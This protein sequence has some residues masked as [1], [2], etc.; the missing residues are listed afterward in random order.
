M[1]GTRKKAAATGTRGTATKGRATTKRGVAAKRGIALTR[2]AKTKHGVS[3]KRAVTSP[4]KSKP[5]KAPAPALTPAALRT[6]LAQRETELALINSIQQGLAAKLDFQAVVDLIGDQ[7][8]VLFATPDL[9]ISWFD[10][11]ANL[12]RTLYAYEHDRRLELPPSAPRPG[13][14][15]ESMRKSRVPHVLNRSL[16][17]KRYNLTPVPGTDNSKSML[18]VPIVVGDRF[19]GDISIENFERE[20]AFAPSDIRLVSTVAGSLGAAL[21][22]AR[23]FDETQRLLKETEQ[24]A[25]ELAVINSIQQGMA[26]KLDF[27][28]I[29]DLVGDK[30]R[31]VFGTGDIGIRWYDE[32]TNL[33]HYLYD[34]EH[35][36]RLTIPPTRPDA[37]RSVRDDDADATT[38]RSEHAR[39]SMRDARRGAVP[40]TDT[41]KSLVARADRRQRSRARQHHDRE[42][43]ARVRVRRS[44]RAAADDGRRE[45][46][47]RAGERA[48]LRRDAAAAQGNRAA[49]RRA[50]GHQQHPAGDRRRSSTSRR[51]SISSATSCARYSAPATSASAGTTSEPT[52]CI[53]CTTSSTACA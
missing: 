34:Y 13:G 28:A 9:S 40:G 33:S 43:R 30:L 23:L 50:R 2:G 46:G 24:R 39:P 10:E 27:Q 26:A 51:S 53:T 6:R 45:H 1:A 12:V 48:P 5:S 11:P 49:Q 16:D 44:R 37:G 29:V 25:A 14:L 32:K 38:A 31:E 42:L 18:S 15:Y 47:R 41:S 21:E 52:W 35:G 3:G 4:A 22:N 20:N 19:L 17:Y 36:K 8:R 7:L